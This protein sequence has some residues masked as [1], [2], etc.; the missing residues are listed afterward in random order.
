MVTCKG[1]PALSPRPHNLSCVSP[2]LPGERGTPGLPGPKG[3][4]GKMGATGP[5][6]MR[7]FKGNSKPQSTCV[8]LLIASPWAAA[9]APEQMDYLCILALPLTS[10]VTLGKSLG[11]AKHSFL[12][13]LM[14]IYLF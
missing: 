9:R 14:F 5:M 3:D 4:D 7:G 13:Y 6:G 1:P 2:G 10:S 8:A 12:F 11:L